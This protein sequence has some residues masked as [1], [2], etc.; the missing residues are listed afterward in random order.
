M[1]FYRYRYIHMQSMMYSY[2]VDTV[3][4]NQFLPLIKICAIISSKQYLC[5]NTVQ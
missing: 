1:Q 5:I 3:M 2:G 4:I